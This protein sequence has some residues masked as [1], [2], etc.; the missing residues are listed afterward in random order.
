MEAIYA[1]FGQELRRARKERGRTQSDLANRVRLGRTSV[2][3]IESGQQRLYLHTLIDIAA[4]L[5]VSPGELLP[6]EPRDVEEIL[7]AQVE[8]LPAREREWIMRVVSPAKRRPK[9]R[10]NGTS[11]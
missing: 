9:K 11:S 4:A 1:R 2:A 8:S 5:R 3:N 6:D 10:G 7:S